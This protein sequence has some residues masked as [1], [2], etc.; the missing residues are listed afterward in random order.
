MARLLAAQLGVCI[1][2]VALGAW[3]TSIVVFRSDAQNDTTASAVELTRA[4]KESRALL[5]MVRTST[6]TARDVYLDRFLT[7]VRSLQ[8]KAQGCKSDLVTDAISRLPADL[9][10]V[11]RTDRDEIDRALEAV[12]LSA[13]SLSADAEAAATRSGQTFVGSSVSTVLWLDGAALAL[14]ASACLIL[15]RLQRRAANERAELDEVLPGDASGEGLATRAAKLRGRAERL[16]QRHDRAVIQRLTLAEAIEGYEAAQDML[17]ASLSETRGEVERLRVS[18]MLDELTGALKYPY[19]VHRIR[20]LLARLL[21]TG[22]PFCLLELDLDNFKD[23][24]DTYGH[25]AGDDALK[26]FATVLRNNCRER[27]LVIRKSGDEFFV[28][29]PDTGL[30]DAL[31]LGERLRTSVNTFRVVS[32]NAAGDRFE[33]PLGASIGVLDASTADIDALRRISDPDLAVREVIS[34]VDAALY[35]AKHAGK[36][37]VRGYE[38]GLRVVDVASSETPPDLPRI[39]RLARSRYAHLDADT[40]VAFDGLLSD[41]SELL[42]PRRTRTAMASEGSESAAVNTDD[43]QAPES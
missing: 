1:V 12:A 36:N 15:Y 13:D 32:T 34:Y 5:A 33:F 18:S 42:F 41:A 39:N 2:L 8:S 29:A 16:A 17:S 30:D 26:D 14:L 20:E 23:I 21:E 31:V 43:D 9:S 19:M 28:L 22:T 40:R 10:A 25:A 37:C 11:A 35:R 38:A 7:S 24:N 4:A 3:A 27:D 6:G